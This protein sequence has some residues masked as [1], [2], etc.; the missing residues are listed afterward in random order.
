MTDRVTGVQCLL[1][2][3]SLVT[4]QND[5]LAVTVLI[6]RDAKPLVAEGH[7]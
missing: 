6:D 4:D 3:E 5:T 1:V 2:T 7:Q